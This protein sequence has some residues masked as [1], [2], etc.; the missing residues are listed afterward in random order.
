MSST[1]EPLPE[2]SL[3]RDRPRLSSDAFN[4]LS[5]LATVEVQLVLRCLD[6][7]CR[8]AAARCNKQLYAAASHPFA[9][10]QEHMVTLEVENEAAA[11]QALGQ[12]VRR[13]LLRLA[14]IRLSL[15]VSSQCASPFYLETFEIPKV[16]AITLPPKGHYRSVPADFLSQL[17]QHPAAAQL[18]SLNVSRLVYQRCSSAELQQ[19]Q[20]L[21]HLHSLS[22]GACACDELASLQPLSLF[23]SLTRLALYMPRHQER[24]IPA[25][26]VCLHL[27]SLGLGCSL[28]RP[29]L[30]HCLAQLPSLQRLA[31]R[32]GDVKHQSASAWA[33]LRSLREI[34]LDMVPAANR[35]LVVLSSVPTLRLLRWH[36]RAP[37]YAISQHDPFLPPLQLLRSLMTDAPLL[38]VELVMPR[39]FD[40]WQRVCIL[41]AVPD[42]LTNDQRRRWDEL[43]QLPMELP[44]VRIV[45]GELEQEHGMT[46]S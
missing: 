45:E 13:S 29:E 46:Q 19:L 10:P 35:L 42:G 11:L 20:T 30:V 26:P 14:S 28:I 2:Q 3:G 36:C 41:V 31:L 4:W 39:T 8:L 23:P 16:H 1:I 15:H 21:P 6:P 7:P 32:G 38:Q 33:A 9:W 22:L 34:Q 12:R 27:V 17:L 24:L 18:R 5:I 37:G 25:L 40:E 43:H 44:R